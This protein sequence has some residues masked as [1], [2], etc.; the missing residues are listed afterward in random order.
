M[1]SFFFQPLKELAL[2]RASAHFCAVLCSAPEHRLQ[3][4]H[5]FRKSRLQKKKP[6]RFPIVFSVLLVGLRLAKNIIKHYFFDELRA[7]ANTTSGRCVLVA[8]GI[9]SATLGAYL[10]RYNIWAFITR[11]VVPARSKRARRVFGQGPQAHCYRRCAVRR[12][13]RGACSAHLL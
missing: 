1:L 12:P 6:T 8:C 4:K 10:F 2:A 5:H 13:W 9:I 3:N 11:D 7:V